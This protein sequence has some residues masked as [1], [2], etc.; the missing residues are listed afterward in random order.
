[1]KSYCGYADAGMPGS[2][3]ICAPGDYWVK[4]CKDCQIKDL[5]AELEERDKLLLDIEATM[6]GQPDAVSLGYDIE[7]R[8]AA[9]KGSKGPKP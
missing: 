1:M 9:I 5:K 6:D 8:M 2:Q 3:V 7:C 4:Q